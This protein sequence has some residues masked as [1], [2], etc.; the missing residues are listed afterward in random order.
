MK[1]FRLS[2]RACLRGAGVAIALPWLEIMETP[3][4]RAQALN[5]VRFLCVYSPNGMLMDKW[6]PVNTGANYTTPELLVPLEPYKADFNVLSGLGNYT[7]S[8]GNIFG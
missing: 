1:R 3:V 8:L 6:V 7:A 4:A 2:R 5:P